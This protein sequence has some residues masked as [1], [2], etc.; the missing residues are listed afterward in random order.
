M[1]RRHRSQGELF[2]TR[3]LLTV[4][5]ILGAILMVVPSRTW[6]W[7]ARPV[8]WILWQVLRRYRKRTLDN[9]AQ[10]GLTGS[11]AVRRGRGSFHSMVLVLFETLAMKRIRARRGVTVDY[12]VTDEAQVTIDAVRAGELPGVLA[13]GGHTGSWET[14]GSEIAKMFEPARAAV[15]YR[16]QRD[17]VLDNWLVST[18][19]SWGLEL[20]D[21]SKFLRFFARRWREKPATAYCFFIDQ[22]ARNFSASDFMGEPGCTVDVPA[23][24]VIRYGAPVLFVNCVRERAGHYRV[25][26]QHFDPAPYL[27]LPEAEQVEALT[28]A[29]N[30]QVARQIEANPDQ[31]TWGHKRW[32]E[33]CRRKAAEAAGETAP[34]SDVAVANPS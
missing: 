9:L 31:W 12:E 5:K 10:H 11:A 27:A 24:I 18:R 21:K 34:P 1:S 14:N 29:F 16:P 3:C 13:I 20:V 23:H 19:N 25:F 26:T 7:I 33:C 8:S 15:S 32:R 6:E 2:I 30:E 28:R 17:P 22:H 4:F